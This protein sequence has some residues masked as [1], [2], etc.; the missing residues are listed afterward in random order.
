MAQIVLGVGVSHS[1][2]LSTPPEVWARH[3][4]RDRATSELLG[5]DGKF[6]TYDE[7]L[8]SADPA[9]SIDPGVWQEQH[10]RMQERIDHIARELAAARPNMAI[11]VGDDQRELF[12]EDGIAALAVS[13][14]EEL[15]DYPPTPEEFT[16]LPV[17]LAEASWA[18]H[19][20]EPDRYPGHPAFAEHLARFVTNSGFDL[21]VM[22]EQPQGRSL[23]H[24]YT[25]ARLRLGLGPDIAMVPLF[26]N[27]Y[28]PPN[29]PSP[30]RCHAFGQRL[31]DAV[32]A[33]P[34]RS[35]VVIVASG[36]LSHFIVDEVLDR[37]VLEAFRAR[38]TTLLH[39]V[40]KGK[41]RSGSSEILNWITAAAA[42]DD[43]EMELL[44][45]I[46]AYRTEAG[47]GVGI[48]FALWHR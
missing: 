3:A 21:C 41:M 22:R 47:T 26:L 6:H 35:R 23:G 48:G 38:D 1:P 11:V 34:E 30:E 28:F 25:F 19:A 8:A 14:A 5:L 9:I 24:A 20:S 44:D 32:E 15:R 29:V 12:R 40:T 2:Q 7:I 45:Y 10:A 31:R 39:E 4:A 16:T 17:G 46:P 18:Q 37:G 27:T 33:W 43:L 42:L 13:L 36:G